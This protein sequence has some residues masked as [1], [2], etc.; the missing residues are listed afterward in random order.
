MRIVRGKEKA[1]S[2]FLRRA[3]GEVPPL[4]RWLRRRIEEVFGARLT[5]EQVVER[6][7]R[8]VRRE[9]DAALLE[10]GQ[11]LD[12]V[13]L[14]SLE[15][16]PEEMSAASKIDKSLA[17]ALELAAD[18]IRSF[19]L[20][21]RGRGQDIDLGEGGLGRLLRPLERVGIYVPG[22]TASYPS[23]VLMTAI[24][25]RVAGV[26]QIILT[27]P[28]APGGGVSPAV[29]AAAELAG[30]DRIFK[31]GGA[32]AIAAMAFG[33]QT[34]PRVDKV[35]GPG[36][37]FV[38]LA[39]KMVYGVVGIDGLH[40]PT[41][42]VIV[43]DEDASPA[44][45]AADLL[46]QAEHDPLA[47]A[48]LI[49]NSLPLGKAVAEE[50]ERQ[51]AS[52]ERQAITRQALHARGGIAVVD[53]IDEAIELANEYAPEHLALLV[54]DPWFY[55][56]R[57][58]N[59]GGVFLGEGCPEAIGDYVAGPSHVMPTGGSARFSSP[60]GVDDFLKV[61][62][63]FALDQESVR[64][65]GQAASALARAEGLTAHARAVE[66]RLPQAR[67]KPNRRKGRPSGDEG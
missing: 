54:K 57:I 53:S 44:L 14:D 55:L 37:I 32:Q 23:T 24:P 42:T 30:V 65:L 41:E 40:G 35:C 61:T 17:S 63:L 20:A 47:S 29:L 28:P 21:F 36:N 46:A 7:I 26:R 56:S 19:H 16:T 45:C 49:T 60:L 58:T 5:A 67:P 6:I 43:A 10:L 18:R 1:R 38:V 48:I 51:L 52:L 31:V 11:K 9:G 22:G 66:M 27:T 25:A 33:T 12:G 2:T 8:Q 13:E 4:P 64:H 3:L 39:K 62:S 59:A 15:V 34:V 50:V